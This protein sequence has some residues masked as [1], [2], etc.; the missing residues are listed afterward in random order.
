MRHLGEALD[1]VRK[2]EY[3][4][5]AGHDPSSVRNTPCRR[6]RRVLRSTANGARAH[7][8]GVDKFERPVDRSLKALL[9]PNKRL[10]TAYVLKDRFGQ[11]R[12]LGAAVLRELAAGL[13]WQRLKP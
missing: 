2:S 7:H 12:R 3:R 6:A 11:L 10:N 4:R 1:E 13:K 8:I 9:S 5:L